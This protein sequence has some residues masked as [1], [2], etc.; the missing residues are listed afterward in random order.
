MPDNFGIVRRL[1]APGQSVNVELFPPSLYQVAI[2]D[3]GTFIVAGVQAAADSLRRSVFESPPVKFNRPALLDLEDFE[4]CLTHPKGYKGLCPDELVIIGKSALARS[5]CDDRF[6]RL[7][8]SAELANEHLLL[9]MTGVSSLEIVNLAPTGETVIK[10]L[11][12][13]VQD[14]IEAP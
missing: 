1:E 11:A 14:D 7:K 6:P 10:D 4:D 8:Y 3:V 12:A 9:H 2:S 13:I 5:T